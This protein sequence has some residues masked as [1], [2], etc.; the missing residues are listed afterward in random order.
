MNITALVTK[1]Y[2]ALEHVEISL[3]EFTPA[4]FNEYVKNLNLEPNDNVYESGIQYAGRDSD[5]AEIN[6]R[7]IHRATPYNGG[8]FETDLIILI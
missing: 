5:N 6:V 7:V 1:T 4:E 8:N 3:V 2:A